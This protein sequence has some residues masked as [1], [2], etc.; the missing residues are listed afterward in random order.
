MR[1]THRR[2]ACAIATSAFLLA[3]AT[4][5]AA[6]PKPAT[7]PAG[8][9]QTVEV[10]VDSASGEDAWA[11]GY[12]HYFPDKVTVHPGDTVTYKSTFTGEPHSVAFGTD[13]QALI[14]LFRSQPPE[15]QSGQAPPPPEAEAKFNELQAKVPPMF[16]EGEGDALQNSVNPCFV[17]TGDIPA[18]STKQCPVTTAPGPFDGTATF[19]NSGFMEDGATFE[20]KLADNIKPGVYLGYCTLHQV[21]MITEIDVV[22]P[23]QPA[24]SAADV[25]AAGQQQLADINAKISGAVD[26]ASK[27]AKPGTVLAGVDGPGV[28]GFA[29]AFLPADTSIKAGE[30]VTWTLSQ[31]APHTVS[32]NPSEAAR[33]IIMKGPDGGYHL[34]PES[35]APAGFTPPAGPPPTG[36]APPP[37]LDGGSWDGTGFFSTGVVF[38]GTF[39]LTFT[40]PG[41]YPY[42]CLIHPDM[43]GTVTVT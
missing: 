37:P 26:E 43:K 27:S 14:E 1:A 24:E 7:T 13:I 3:S 11:G 15:V 5:G 38:G 30:T 21:G 22:A 2:A 18:D 34:N 17:A 19:W 8:G 12:I 10:G 20:M 42:V 36:D 28:P 39:T 16:P 32:F 23:D 31:N 40:T 29:S 6:A 4:T 25:A 33:T 35:F 9:P 41:T